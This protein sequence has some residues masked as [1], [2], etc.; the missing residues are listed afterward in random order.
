MHKDATITEGIV[1]NLTVNQAFT[2]QLNGGITPQISPTIDFE[3]MPI[4]IMAKL[5]FDA[6]KV[7]GR[8]AMR[9]MT[10]ADLKKTYGGKVSWRALYSKSGAAAQTASVKMTVEEKR[11][12]IVKLQAQLDE[13]DDYD[14]AVDEANNNQ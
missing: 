13:P 7:R 1:H 9:G 2:V 14:K 11:A 10:E 12:M 5:A 6:L 4:E 8:G 3:F